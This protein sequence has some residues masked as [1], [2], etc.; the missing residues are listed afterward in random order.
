MEQN[1]QKTLFKALILQLEAQEDLLASQERRIEDLKKS[2]QV[3]LNKLV[4]YELMFNQ[5]GKNVTK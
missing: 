2:E 5:G 4:G 1:H 3:L